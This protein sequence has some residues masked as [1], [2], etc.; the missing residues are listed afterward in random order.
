MDIEATCPK[1]QVRSILENKKYLQ[2]FDQDVYWQ[3]YSKK[4]MSEEVLIRSKIDK[5]ITEKVKII[6][7]S[8]ADIQFFD[9]QAFGQKD[10]ILQQETTI[11]SFA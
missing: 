2:F 4:L 11:F 3:F 5:A 9:S 6:A 10:L 7:P 1:I 8:L